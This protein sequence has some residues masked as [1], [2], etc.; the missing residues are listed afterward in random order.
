MTDVFDQPTVCLIMLYGGMLL[1]V[2][3]TFFRLLRSARQTG[4]C[5]AVCDLL[6]LLC[7]AAI[8]A[9]CILITSDGVLRAYAIAALGVG[10][11]LTRYAFSVMFAHLTKNRHK[12]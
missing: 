2:L 1:G 8:S 9:Y 7:A 11:F 6:F 4:W 12:N 10:F 3:Y 5:T